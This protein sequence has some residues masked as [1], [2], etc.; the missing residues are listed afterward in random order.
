MRRQLS[1]TSVSE[2][3]A[4]LQALFGVAWRVHP[5]IDL[6]AQYTTRLT[7]QRVSSEQENRLIDTFLG[8]EQEDV[9]TRDTSQDTFQLS[10]SDVRVGVA[11][12]F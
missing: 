10:A 6:V 11:L 5:S 4:G 8:M 12:R 1:E 2:M 7:Y 3:E 9:D